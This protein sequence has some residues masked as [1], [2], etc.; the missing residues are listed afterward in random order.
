MDVLDVGKAC[1]TY[2]REAA[3]CR[4]ADLAA[5]W[6]VTRVA[7]RG[8]G[9]SHAPWRG[10]GHGRGRGRGGQQP[11]AETQAAEAA[12][13][14]DQATAAANAVGRG[15]CRR[16]QSLE[17]DGNSEAIEGDVAACTLYIQLPHLRLLVVHEKYWLA[18]LHK[19]KLVEF[20]SSRHPTSIKAGHSLLFAV[21]MRHRRRGSDSLIHA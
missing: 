2:A 12:Q 6:A 14:A 19:D 8:R 9:R 1:M 11:E 17:V 4:L 13:A 3:D 20:R 18:I 15:R 16:R 10:P 5:K 7:C 21:V